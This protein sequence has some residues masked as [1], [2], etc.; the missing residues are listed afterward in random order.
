MDISALEALLASPE[1]WAEYRRSLKGQRPDLA[2]ATLTGA[3]LI[4][5]DLAGADLTD[6]DLSSAAL[7]GA[8]LSSAKL[9]RVDLTGADLTG[10]SFV[11]ADLTHADFSGAD[12][13][14][15]NLTGAIL[16]G[17]TFVEADLTRTNLTGTETMYSNFFR[18]RVTLETVSRAGHPLEDVLRDIAMPPPL[19][20][21]LVRIQVPLPMSVDPQVFAD[22]TFSVA[23]V[24]RLVSRVGARLN[25]TSGE[26]FRTDTPGSVLVKTDNE[27]SS[28]AV[29]RTHYGSPW[30]IDLAEL[31]PSMVAGAAAAGMGG[32]ALVLRKR[33]ERLLS[34]LLTLARVSERKLWLESRVERRRH[35]LEQ[36]RANTATEIERRSRREAEIVALHIDADSEAGFRQRVTEAIPD[37]EALRVVLEAIPQ[38]MP[39]I[40]EGFTVLTGESRET[41]PRVPS[42]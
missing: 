35:E 19:E 8:T 2:R 1:E 7:N 16:V 26:D 36:E 10:S 23:V 40:G 37:P 27:S 18:A 39:L 25:A 34:F 17:A 6:A 41:D 30:W 20:E 9:L 13:T 38:L 3:N 24:A 12:L 32:A 5:L 28:V 15:A 31:G 21:G 11:R 42:P 4:G 33:N 29:V 22:L 14:G